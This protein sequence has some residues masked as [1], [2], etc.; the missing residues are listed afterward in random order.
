MKNSSQ[1]ELKLIQ[2]EID[3][4]E[5]YVKKGCNDLTWNSNSKYSTHFKN[6][7]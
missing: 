1:V 6:F 3:V 2:Q 7:N 4:I 5:S